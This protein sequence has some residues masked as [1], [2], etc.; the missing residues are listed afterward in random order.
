[1]VRAI[2]ILALPLL[3]LPAILGEAAPQATPD[4]EA[5]VLRPYEVSVHVDLVQLYVT[6]RDGDDQ[7]AGDLSEQNFEVSEDGVRQK[8]RLFS[9]E[10]IPV[11]VG[12]VVDHSG[13]M[14]SKLAEV[15]AAARSFARSIKPEDQ[16]FVV[17]FNEKATLGLPPEIRLTNRPEALEA[18]ILRAP[19]TGQT[20]LYDAAV[21]ALEQLPAGGREKKVIIIIS[22]GGDNVSA[23]TLAEVLELAG[24]SSALIYTI[25][26]FTPD[27]PDRN[28]GVL[29]RLARETGGESFIPGEATEVVSIC[30]G[31]ARDIRNQYSLGY[32]SHSMKGPGVYRKI[33]V[34]AR[35]EGRGKL[36][37]RARAGY[38][39]GAPVRQGAR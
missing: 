14:R 37:V 26:I 9:H 21:L 36:H 25:G 24:R 1:M 38:I 33:R 28:S 18:A 6:V 2:S 35:P 16:M 13:S 3:A 32:V 30:E 31:I 34:T 19:L 23:R 17:N 22:D 20:A 27:D 11:T 8:V 12:L 15:I 5:K 4:G 7:F 39:A 10:D 29:R